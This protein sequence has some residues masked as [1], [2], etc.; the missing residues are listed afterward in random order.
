[1]GSRNRFKT[2]RLSFSTD[3]SSRKTQRKKVES[4]KSFFDSVR[5]PDLGFSRKRPF[6]ADKSELCKKWP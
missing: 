1:M 4:K 3:R 2:F 5:K 6:S